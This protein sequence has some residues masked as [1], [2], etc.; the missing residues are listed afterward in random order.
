MVDPNTEFTVLSHMASH[1]YV[2][3]SPFT[4][5][6]LP[7]SQYNAEWMNHIDDWSQKNLQNK[8][9]EEEG[10]FA[11]EEFPNISSITTYSSKRYT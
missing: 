8:L 2:V 5:Y 9:I 4:Y 11:Y 1:G 6:S 7:T 10:K 3:I